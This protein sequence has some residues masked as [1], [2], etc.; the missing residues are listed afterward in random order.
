[1]Y[2]D[3]AIVYFGLTRSTKNV[4][5]T[6]FDYIFN[7]LKDN[8]LSYKTFMHTWKTNDNKQKVWGKTS[9]ID[10]DYEEYKLL[11]P[12][13]YKLENQ[14]DF[15]ET[16]NMD[17]YFYK[18]VYEKRGNSR[19]GGEWEPHL[20]R[21][22]LC[23]LK[24]KK[25]ALEMV[26]NFVKEGNRIKYV[27]F[28]RPD[29][30]FLYPLPVKELDN[31]NDIFIPDEGRMEGYNDRFAIAHYDKSHLY[32][33]RIDEIAEFRKTQGRIVSEKYVKY[34][35]HK[36]KLKLKEIR[37]NFRLERPDGSSVGPLS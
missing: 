16:I 9:N 3:F 33:K 28:I 13:F 17:D 12:D 15:I 26:D 24:S 5:K 1:M 20:V 35:V 27:M 7:V 6:H 34:I 23:A 30:K 21:N 25:S 8:N 32:G 19:H 10:I 37:F 31:D 18:D 29:T 11:K 36:H 2:Y 22:H 14:N 4:Y